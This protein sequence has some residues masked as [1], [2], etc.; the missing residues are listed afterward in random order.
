MKDKIMSSTVFS[1]GF[2][3]ILKTPLSV[4]ERE[5]LSEILWDKDSNL[6][7]NNEGTLVYSD[8]RDENLG[9]GLHFLIDGD[10]D[11]FL[12]ELKDMDIL[13]NEDS[14]HPYNCLW[15]NGSESYMSVLKKED[16]QKQTYNRQRD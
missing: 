16:Y 12:K 2:F 15:Y 7:I 3:A 4:D 5:E 8:I 1:T 6:N 9:Y 10:K 11:A 13:I 14:I